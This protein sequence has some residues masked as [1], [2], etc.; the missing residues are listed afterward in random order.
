MEHASQPWDGHSPGHP[1][2]E[3]ARCK[4]VCTGLPV[5]TTGAIPKPQGSWWVNVSCAPLC[6]L[7]DDI[8]ACLMGTAAVQRTFGSVLTV[9]L[10]CAAEA[11]VD[12]TT[13]TT[14]WS[15]QPYPVLASPTRPVVA[16]PTPPVVASPTRR[17][18][19]SPMPLCQPAF[20]VRLCPQPASPPPGPLHGRKKRPHWCWQPHRCP[21][22]F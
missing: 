6:W 8:E 7:T 2:R 16:S 3:S 18:V 17:V 22:L 11:V 5:S 13:T 20:G 14:L 15:H 12:G 4:N 1:L 10:A 19:G 9:A 21:I